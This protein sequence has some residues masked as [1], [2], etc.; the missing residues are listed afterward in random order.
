M[1]VAFLKPSFLMQFVYNQIAASLK[2]LINL[3]YA[4]DIGHFLTSTLVRKI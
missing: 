2:K 1:P 3:R 4:Q